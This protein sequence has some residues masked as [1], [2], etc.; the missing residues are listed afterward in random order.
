MQRTLLSEFPEYKQSIET[1]LIVMH[2]PQR[3]LVSKYSEKQLDLEGKI[4]FIFV[5]SAFF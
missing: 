5:G 1:K 3:I 4:K 2:P